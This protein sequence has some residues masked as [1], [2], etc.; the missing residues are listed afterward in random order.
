MVIQMSNDMILQIY[1][2]RTEIAV[3]ILDLYRFLVEKYAESNP[4]E[5]V[6]LVGFL[7]QVFDFYR[8]VVDK[9]S[10]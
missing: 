8:Q 10:A 9:H 2:K 4:I 5:M 3:E 1:N 6:T 7:K